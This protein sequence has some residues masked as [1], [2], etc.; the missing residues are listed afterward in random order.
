MRSGPPDAP[1][2]LPTLRNILGIWSGQL[3]CC[4]PGPGHTVLGF[5][6]LSPLPA[7]SPPA[8]APLLWLNILPLFMLS[9]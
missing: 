9:P 5:T 8:L 7:V 4:Y 3:L 2:P 1:Q 6:A